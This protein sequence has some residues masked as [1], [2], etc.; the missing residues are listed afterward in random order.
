MRI[1][2]FSQPG[3]KPNTL[4]TFDNATRCIVLN[5]GGTIGSGLVPAFSAANSQFWVQG[6]AFEGF[7]DTGGNCSG[8]ALGLFFGGAGDLVWGNQFGGKLG[9]LT[10]TA[11]DVD[12]AGGTNAS[13]GGSAPSQRNIIAGA[14]CKNASGSS[15]GFGISASYDTFFGGPAGMSIVGNLIGTDASESTSGGNDHNVYLQTSSNNV[16]HNVIVNGS[17]G[18]ELQ[19]GQ[20][21][22]NTVENNLIGITNSYCVLFP[23]P[24]CYAGTAAGN[25]VGIALYGDASGA[26]SGNTVA[27][28]TAWYN[29]I[30]IYLKMG[31]NGSPEHDA[32]L[33]NSIY[34]SDP[35]YGGIYTGYPVNV[36][37]NDA[38]PS[39]Q[40]QPN[41]GLNN[42]II[43]R[44]IGGTFSGLV[45]GTL[46]STNASYTIEVFSSQQCDA[47]G[48]G[49]GETFHGSSLAA[50][51]NAP[52]GNNGSTS[53]SI[54]FN[55]EPGGNLGS[56]SV[57][58][59]G[60]TFVI[61]KSAILWANLSNISS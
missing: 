13:I 42:P 39:V 37:Y 60:L 14:S 2:G 34:A 43:T 57:P 12:I 27:F 5:G 31:A 10:L 3:S 49:E 41:R 54:P 32:I 40:A 6:L 58:K 21:T 22:N 56:L 48:Y 53:F 46:A 47:G 61:L 1:D 35:I 45:T 17:V 52:I 50:I 23:S 44:A 36:T 38:D 51:S 15:E 9:N 18:V 24:I 26:A 8:T 30:G 28:N 4:A 29:G 20:A 7:H 11:N 19:G 55:V 59:T 25:S 16:S 33:G